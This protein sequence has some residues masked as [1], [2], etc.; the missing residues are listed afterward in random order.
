ML[1]YIIFPEKQLQRSPNPLE[2]FFLAGTSI[3]PMNF[4]GIAAFNIFLGENNSGK[5]RFMRD[6]MRDSDLQT[7]DLQLPKN[8]DA[9]IGIAERMLKLAEDFIDIKV[10]ITIERAIDFR[11]EN[12]EE[13]VKLLWRTDKIP[14]QISNLN[15]DFS[16]FIKA[17]FNLLQRM[18]ATSHNESEYVKFFSEDGAGKAIEELKRLESD[19]DYVVRIFNSIKPK[20]IIGKFFSNTFYMPAFETSAGTIRFDKYYWNTNSITE[21][22]NSLSEY[23]IAASDTAQNIANQVA[24]IRLML[25]RQLDSKANPKHRTYIPILRTART[26]ITQDGNRLEGSNDIFLHTTIHD[27]NLKDTGV[28]VDTGFSLYDAI[29]TTR[30]ARHGGRTSFKAFE[31]FLSDTFFNGKKVEVVA[32]RIRNERGGNIIVAVEGV[33]RDIH[34]L[35]DGIQA[36]IMLLY[37]LF[38]APEQAWFF[39]E[40]PELHLHPGFQRLFI[41]T[42]TTNKI[43]R[44][45][46]LTIFLTTHSNHIL[47]FA[48]DDPSH[49]NI[50]TFRRREGVGNKSTYQIQLSSQ[51]DI[52]N[53]NVLGVRNSSVFLANCSIWVEG[54][55]DR[56]YFRAY[57]QAY[58]NY[59]AE[60]EKDQKTVSLLE[61]LHYAFLEYAGGNVTHFDFTTHSGAFTA[62]TIEDIKALSISNRVMLVAD[63]DDGKN[64]RHEA[65]ESQQHAGFQY[66]VLSVKEVENMLSPQLIVKGL[67]KLFRSRDFDSATII[68]AGYRTRYLGAY[69]QEKY[70]GFPISFYGGSGTIGS[71]YKRLLA[72]AIVPNLKWEEMSLA[73]QKLT[74]VLYQF[75]II[76]NPRLG[77]N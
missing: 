53:L 63:R 64:T 39:I 6:I 30:N 23:A 27:Y 47:D 51:R 32:E 56:L 15:I 31:D 38:I 8:S 49:V 58:L 19:F 5:S 71:S 16:E 37:P 29:D 2:D 77:S 72:E 65:R 25:E 61:G 24:K 33:E 74:E 10:S 44:A 21:K 7:I 26:L 14:S 42:I 50:F 48:L 28:I 60:R 12:A 45:K 35:G 11:Y 55:S 68:Q 36:I 66:V 62:Q 57:I 59:L 17:F 34:D 40:E 73:A 9:K 52:E 46:N 69:L 13:I 43:L 3:L 54:I 22:G 1:R 4:G 67:K 75:I 41:E 70:G 18:R 76:H 20:G